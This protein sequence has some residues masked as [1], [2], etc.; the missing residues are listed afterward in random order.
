M[1]A[2]LEI[3]DDLYREIKI[4][5]AREGVK[6]KDLVAQTLTAG[7]HTSAQSAVPEKKA[8]KGSIF[9]LIKGPLGPLLQGKDIRRLSFL[10]DIDDLESYQR[11]LRR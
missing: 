4:R 7:L 11:S 8:K 6:V 9:P 1:K 2:T 10:D 3:P 5:A